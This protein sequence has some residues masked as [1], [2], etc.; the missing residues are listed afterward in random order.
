MKNLKVNIIGLA[1]AGTLGFGI[2]AASAE[3]A[4]TGSWYAVPGV[5]VMHAD[6]DLD[7]DSTGYGGFLRL[8]KEISEHWDVQIGASYAKA[9]EDTGLPGAGGDYKQ[10]LFGVDALYMFSR[11]KFRPFL[12]AGI[13]AARN[14]VDYSG[15]GITDER[16]TSWMANVGVGAQYLFNDRFGLQADLRHVWSKADGNVPGGPDYD[17]TVGNTYLNLGVV[18]RFGA[19]T[20][21]AAAEP[22]AE[23]EPTP[24]P[25]VEPAPAPEPEPAPVQG[26]EKPAFEK[27][28]LD[29]TVLFG[30][31]KAVIRD[32]GKRLLDTE[33]VEKMKAHPEVEVVLITGH[34]DR[35]GTDQYN[36]KLSERRAQAV[37]KYLM[38]QGIDESRLH[39]QAKGESD[40]VV[41]CKGVYGKKAIECLQPN[42][43]VVV[44]V[45]VQRASE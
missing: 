21:V 25:A 11:D 32:E 24:E 45:E 23:P 18:F 5:S 13:G 28:T 10:T 41:A 39:T 7:A 14:K 27:V 33:V 6:S 34:T 37:K 20:P 9:D 38:S 40:P 42:R 29:A 30:F 19:P 3:E 4:Y 15:I 8:G 35:I 16:R 12:L 31:D 36:M 1:V 17:H 2:S 26:P 44:E 43:R 22:V